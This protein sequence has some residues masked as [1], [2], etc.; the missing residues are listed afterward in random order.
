VA[1]A[2]SF[3]VTWLLRSRIVFTAEAA[4]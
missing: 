3:V 2:A 4:A 1:I